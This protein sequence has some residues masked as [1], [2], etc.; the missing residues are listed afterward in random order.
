MDRVAN[1]VV[2]TGDRHFTMACDLTADFDDPEAAVVGAEVV[3]TSVSS[4]G[5]ENPAEW[6]RTWDPVIA[7][8][9]YW[10][11]GDVRRGYVVCDVD[12]ERALAT[13]R[14]ASSVEHHSATVSTGRRFVVES[15]RAGVED[16]D[17]DADPP[18]RPEPR[19]VA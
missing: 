18:G 9:P 19:Q 15:G 6:R 12:R 17:A 8:S 7:E 16:A 2:L 1:P 14:V 11:Y 13:L 5:D 10:K 4:G 3:G